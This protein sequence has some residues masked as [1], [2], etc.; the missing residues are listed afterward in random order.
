MTYKKQKAKLGAKR[1]QSK[2]IAKLRKMSDRLKLKR[3]KNINQQV[4]RNMETPLT[5]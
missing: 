5:I 2:I 4:K 3:R 1:P